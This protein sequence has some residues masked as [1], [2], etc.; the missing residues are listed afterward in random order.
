MRASPPN[1][2][3]GSKSSRKVGGCCGPRSGGWNSHPRTLAAVRASKLPWLIFLSLAPDAGAGIRCCAMLVGTSVV[4][5]FSILLL[6][7]RI[8]ILLASDEC[9]AWPRSN[10]IVARS[11]IAV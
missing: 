8:R 5:V 1:N 4:P 2:Q 9:S 3:R 6:L 11:Y 7:P 10:H